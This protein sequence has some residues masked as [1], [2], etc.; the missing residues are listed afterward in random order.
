MSFLCGPFR[1]TT[2][3]ANLLSAAAMLWLTLFGCGPAVEAGIIVSF[4]TS[5]PNP[6]IAGSSGIIDVFVRTDV[7]SETLDGFNVR[8]GLTPTGGSPIGGL[9]FSATQSEAQ[10]G[11]TDYVFFGISL[12]QN[13]STTIGTVSGGGSLYTGF[14]ASDDGSD[15]P[16]P[17][18]PVPVILTTTDRLLYRLDLTAVA[19]GT[20]DIDVSPG[21]TIFLSDQFE[22]S[23]AIT[24][25]STPAS[26]TVNGAAAVP[27]P[28]SMAFL[29]VTCTAVALRRRFRRPQ[30]SG[31]VHEC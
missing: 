26:L 20:Y 23:S 16:F 10:L 13:T 24:F 18:N 19:A 15:I 17:A 11:D 7:G 3:R 21:E 22:E 28:A 1:P 2:F 5:A 25:S 8:V 9:I 6:M 30:I 14:D 12:S 29:M 31:Q 27:E 4:G